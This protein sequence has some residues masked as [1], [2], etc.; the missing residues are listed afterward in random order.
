MSDEETIRVYNEK[1]GDY[2]R[3]FATDEPDNSLKSF[4]SHLPRGAHVLDWGCGPATSSFH[5]QEAG[6]TPDA[7]DASAKMVAVAK[8][9]YRLNARLGKFTD[10]LPKQFYHGVWANFSLL[11][12]SREAFPTH[13]QQIHEALLLEGVLH[14]GLKRGTGEKRD[15]LGRHYTFYETEELKKY[16]HTAEFKILDIHEGEEAGFAGSIDPFVLILSQRT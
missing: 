5:M 3:R 9:Q 10:E 14:I 16:L 6:F 12:A 13:L 11:H 8:E 4:M 2:T 15:K 1:A 7:M